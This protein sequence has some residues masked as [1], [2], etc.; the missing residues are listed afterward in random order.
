MLNYREKILESAS[1]LKN[2]IQSPPTMGLVLGSGLG[3]L[4]NAISDRI[5]IAYND[6]PHF[7][8]TTVVGH[9]GSLLFGKFKDKHVVLMQGRF[10][11]YEGY[12]MKQVVFP[13][14][15]LHQLGV[16]SMILTNSCGG[17]NKDYT[18]GDIVV[19][20]DF[21]SL[22]SN[23][24]LIGEND[25]LLGPRFPDM[26]EPYSN[27]LKSIAKESA[28]HLKLP[29][30]EGVYGF[31]SGPYYET[32]AE[33]RAFANMGCDL[34][35]MSTVPETIACNHMGVEVLAFAVVTNMATGIQQKKH[36]HH[37]VVKMAKQASE[38]LTSWL[39]DLIEKL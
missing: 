8:T 17:I 15:V 9:A 18:P 30:K 20:D 11:Y 34:I 3:D 26:T 38:K 23:N 33:I 22:V 13:Y 27:R 6:I 12:T 10:H 36:D 25:D 5:E 2:R 4:S 29:Y 16:Q 19:I 37:H 24:P 39:D 21:I 28:Q 14:Y 7:P 31:F 1:Y 35:G 32:R